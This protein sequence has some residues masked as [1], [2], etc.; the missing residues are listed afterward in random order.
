MRSRFVV[1]LLLVLVCVCSPTQNAHADEQTQTSVLSADRFDPR[2]VV[3]EPGSTL[4]LASKALSER[5]Y[6]DARAALQASTSAQGS[7]AYLDEQYLLGRVAQIQ[8]D[9][10]SANRA[11]SIVAAS[12]HPLGSW[13]RFFEAETLDRNRPELAL[14]I[15]TALRDR[16]G[17]GAVFARV[18]ALIDRLQSRVLTP[19]TSVDAQS[20]PD[21]CDAELR[22]A[23]ELFRA[24]DRRTCV[25]KIDALL[26]HCDS[27]DV[28]SWAMFVRGRAL[29]QLG[30]HQS[31][32][33][34]FDEVV[35]LSPTHRL[36]DDAL[37]R[38]AAIAQQ[39][40][41][42]EGHAQR[43]SRVI[44]D[45]PEGDM[46][47]DAFFELA[48][49]Q[50]EAGAYDRALAVL[51]RALASAVVEQTEDGIGRLAYWRARTLLD[52]GRAYDASFA[53]ESVALRYP[54]TYYAQLALA[55]LQPLDADRAR[56]IEMTLR[57]ASTSTDETFE[58][59]ALMQTPAFER[60]VALLRV[61]DAETARLEV[62][63][64]GAF[65]AS[66]GSELL[67]AIAALWKN[68]GL[69]EESVRLARRGLITAIQRAS[70]PTVHALLH[71]AYPRAFAPEIED[72]AREAGIASSLLRAIAREESGF[73][74]AAL[75][76]VRAHGLVQLMEGTARRFARDLNLRVNATTLHEPRTNL[77]I[78]AA[79]LSFL[80]TRYRGRIN[81]IPAAY[82]AGEGAA[83]R[84]LRERADLEFDEW[85]EE[86]PYEESRRYTRR[87]LQ[88]WGVYATLE[89]ATLPSLAWISSTVRSEIAQAH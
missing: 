66:A 24:R 70:L 42:H 36:A 50:R 6:R 20:Q 17:S 85:V 89:G 64:L 81:V 51:D 25:E 48:W 46:R 37:V 16:E 19:G 77:R 35:S 26:A 52:M 28:R 32:I 56:S 73:D 68:A 63:A 86:I 39:L 31:A 10:A 41:D 65:S 61:G 18:Q 21:T 22:A 15:A 13:A 54:H 43:L 75:S 44:E 72:A 76:P 79:F 74:P 2:V 23:Q 4:A 57:S 1:T 59:I 38:G 9:W 60:A 71:I 27:V 29:T 83:D 40:G 33:A 30:D 87:V 82:N 53:F 88:S 55:R 3:P 7:D 8:G 78:G 84:W 45:L 49:A 14:S 12:A 5:R 80:Q 47:A 34:C 11:F 67:P 62:E 69:R 58:R